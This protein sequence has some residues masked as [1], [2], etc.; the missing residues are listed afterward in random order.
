MSCHVKRKVLSSILILCFIFTS[1]VGCGK[2]E[3]N[4]SN[5]DKTPETNR[6][7]N[8]ETP[9]AEKPKNK[10]V[11]LRIFNAKGE[12]AVK[13]EEICKAYSE[14]TGITV[15]PFSVGSGTSAIELLRAQMS[16]KTPPAIYSIKGLT[17]LPE[18]KESGSVLDLTTST[19]A[20]F[21]Q[22]VNDIPESM[23]LST[24]GKESLGIP[25]NVE[26]YGY[27]VDS[28]MLEDL[29]GK[30]NSLKVLAD[31]RVCNYD[32][33]AAFCDI[34]DKYI[35]SPSPSN[36]KLNGNTYTLQSQKAGRA[37][38]LTGVFAF[39]GSEKW[40]YGDHSINVMLN[41]IFS[42]AGEA[43][44]IKQQQYEQLRAP[45]TAYMENMKMVTSHVAGLEGHGVR[46]PELINKATFGYDQSVQA[47]G[48][49][50]ALFLQQGNWVAI[51][52]EKVDPSV[53]SR[54]SFIPVKMPV[55]NDMIKTGKTA[56][57]FN[58]SIPIYVPNYY[59]INAKV[60]ADEQEAAIDFLIWLSKP[61][62]IQKY[63]I[64][65]LKFIPYNADS[66]YTITDSFSKSIITYMDEGNF[67][68]NPYMGVPKPW[69]RDAIASKLM[70]EYLTKKDWTQKDINTFI[71]NAI[72]GLIELTSQ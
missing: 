2:A 62:N 29:F 26:G 23:R 40:T 16:S 20:T 70:E 1:L 50:K 36:V 7:D 24:D 30:E 66:S 63:V 5:P 42:S 8:T 56:E 34:V 69:Y 12:T 48:D 31:L 28:Q 61:E 32:E 15:E 72:T 65:K 71:D 38:N 14:E 59:A 21:A 39:A 22:I 67:L 52:I 33:F 18:W 3:T 44:T 46:G 4:T 19:N 45:L 60:S 55:T 35:S 54:S 41:M 51:N 25:F 9:N 10:D 58:S 64:N 53:A 27:M 43:N 49:G 13:F 37:N 47:F 57:E 68:S 17:E 6:V 11:V